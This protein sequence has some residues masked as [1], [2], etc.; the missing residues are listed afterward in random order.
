MQY[1]VLITTSQL[2]TNWLIN[3]S[4]LSVY[5]QTGIDR[6]RWCVYVIDDN[7]S[8]E[9]FA[10]I[11]K[12]IN[13]L[14][15]DHQLGV[16]DFPTTLLKNHRTRF[17]SGTGAWNT[18]LYA[19]YRRCPTGFV[20]ILDDDDEY[21]PQH[22]A[23]C[24]AAIGENT[25]AVFSR[26]RWLNADGSTTALNLTKAQLLPVNFFVG[27]PGVQG[28]NMFFKTQS[29]IDLGGFDEALPNTTD[30]DLMIRF[31]RKY[32]LRQIVVLEKI[33]VLHYNH[34][35][36]KVNNNFPR[37]QQ[38]LELFYQKYRKD[39]PPSAYLKSLER[40]KAF[41]R[42]QP[43]REQIVICMP[44]KNAAKTVTSAVLSVVGQA[45]TSGEVILLIGND[46][47]TDGSGHIVEELA[48]TYPNIT[49]LNVNLN[50]TSRNRNFL[51]EYARTNFPQ[52]ALIGRLDADDRLCTP[53][54]IA[55]VE[56]LFNEHQFDVLIAGNKQVKDGLMQE[57]KN[58]P[59]QK[60]LND[61]Y[62]LNRL[63][64]MAEGNAKAELPSCNTFLR[65][66]VRIKYPEQSSAEDH[67]FTVLLLLQKNKLDILIA[68]ELLYCEYSLDGLATASNKQTDN[69]RCSRQDLLNFY[70]NSIC[71]AEESK[72]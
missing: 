40:A 29:L 49:V 48:T 71:K 62:L 25:L 4:L 14:R 66:D 46:N 33:N 19:I 51:N 68:E 21:L 28:S 72:R 36:Q 37:K 13:R 15:K 57:W 65:P 18:G 30:R 35:A 17:M 43:P 27:N 23:D 41:F 64:E 63:R 42:Y 26:L 6:S 56:G 3:R 11:R 52:C 47:S 53:G 55:A 20:S 5:R 7:E 58:K 31:L 1:T 60:L 12:R 32:D 9:E 10:T 8:A 69:Y 16:K 70:K 54:T 50:S 59:N 38:G 44:L 34:T 24:V 45:G 61:A 39:F 67:W 22:L 2:R